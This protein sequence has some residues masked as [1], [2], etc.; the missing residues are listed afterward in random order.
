MVFILGASSLDHALRKLT[1]PSQKRLKDTC[2]T[3]PG[4][5]LNFNARDSQKT[6]RYY[7]NDLI[8][9][10][11]AIIKS[12][13]RRRIDNNRKLCSEQLIILLLMCRTNICAI[14]YCRRNGTKHIKESLI[15]T[16]ILVLNAV[17][18]FISKRKAKGQVLIEKYKELH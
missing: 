2:F 7:R 13:S 5:S 18:D 1:A 16:G 15:S 14:V 4:L 6:I 3:K 9:W 11:N 8:I 10:H 17:K 12:I